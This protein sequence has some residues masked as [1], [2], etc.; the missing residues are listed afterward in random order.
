MIKFGVKGGKE[1]LR[2]MKKD[3]RKRYSMRI[4]NYMYAYEPA[5]CPRLFQRR[6]RGGLYNLSNLH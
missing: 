2:Y 4:Y 1:P 6:G 3:E 5:Q